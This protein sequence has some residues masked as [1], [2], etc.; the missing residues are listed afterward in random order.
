M[1]GS[2]VACR[3]DVSATGGIAITYSAGG[4]PSYVSLSGI[5]FYAD[6]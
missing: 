5:Q 2:N 4:G 3:V 1:S 6:Q